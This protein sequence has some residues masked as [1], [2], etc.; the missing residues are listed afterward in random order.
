MKLNMN[1]SETESTTK[2]VFFPTNDILWISSDVNFI[3][4]WLTKYEVI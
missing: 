4:E 1:E 2:N 3:Y